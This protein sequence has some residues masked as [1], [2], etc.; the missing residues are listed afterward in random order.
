MA[1]R[2]A[3]GRIH[4]LLAETLWLA[5]QTAKARKTLIDGLDIHPRQAGLIESLSRLSMAEKRWAEA[6]NWLEV[7]AGLDSPYRA[8]FLERLHT[9]YLRLGETGLARKTLQR[10][11]EETDLLM[12]ETSLT[13][14]GNSVLYG[15]TAPVR[16]LTILP[17]PRAGN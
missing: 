7:G 11:Q 4:R 10:H 6:R 2:G 16:G 13:H 15:D 12:Q 17:P 5:R 1:D 9:V 14:S 3:E 8:V